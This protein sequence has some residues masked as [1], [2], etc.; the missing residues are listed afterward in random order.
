MTVKTVKSV[1]KLERLLHKMNN[2]GDYP[3]VA[4][5]DARGTVALVYGIDM[6]DTMGFAA[7]LDPGEERERGEDNF[8]EGSYIT[9]FESDHADLVPPFTVLYR[10]PTTERQS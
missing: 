7:L 9:D 8:A 4:V 6:G 1:D 3:T 10:T 2:R 5:L